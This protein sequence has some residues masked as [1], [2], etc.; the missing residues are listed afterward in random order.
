[1]TQGVDN[2]GD[3][4]ADSGSGTGI[5][6]VLVYY[7]ILGRTASS[8]VH[9]CKIDL[10]TTLCQDSDNRGKVPKSSYHMII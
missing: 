10:G 2:E 8:D 4:G 5:N 7:H 3:H 1:M 6:L 9:I